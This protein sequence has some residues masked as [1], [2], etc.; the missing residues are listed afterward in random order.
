M[1]L[2]A[3][4]AS[5]SVP[6]H[7]KGH[8]HRR[9]AAVSF[10]W[11]N[12]DLPDPADVITS[13]PSSAPAV[14][15]AHEVAV[16]ASK[17]V[18]MPSTSPTL[19]FASSAS[20][21]SIG[22]Q[23]TTLSRRASLPD[24]A[25]EE[26]ITATASPV[27][28]QRTRRVAFSDDVQEIPSGEEGDTWMKSED[29][30]WPV[31]GTSSG[32]DDE[33]C[34]TID[35]SAA[36]PLVGHG[37]TSTTSSAG[38]LMSKVSAA[39]LEPSPAL[40]PSAIVKP[41]PG[42]PVLNKHR[43]KRSSF[44]QTTKNVLSRR[45]S[46]K[47]P[48]S[49]IPPT[50]MPSVM[51]LPPPRS[52]M[53]DLDM[54]L[55]PDSP[56]LRHKKSGSFNNLPPSPVKLKPRSAHRRAGSAPAD[57]LFSFSP[58]PASPDTRKRKMS[59]IVESPLSVQAFSMT[60]SPEPLSSQQAFH[61]SLSNSVLE[62]MTALEPA[63]PRTADSTGSSA[64]GSCAASSAGTLADS[65]MPGHLDAVDLQFYDH[66]NQPVPGGPGG[67]LRDATYDASPA[68]AALRA[69]ESEE[70]F[71]SLVST[72]GSSTKGDHSQLGS[73]ATGLK[74]AKRGW[75]GVLHRLLR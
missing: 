42:S 63:T 53:I 6:A 28:R 5:L 47:R 43:R 18:A 19:T 16:V 12:M 60:T 29:Y 74:S 9:S 41:V 39:A 51:P 13:H 35:L 71:R 23:D 22:D 7:K 26:T 40:E 44:L 25:E 11:R 36:G 24:V 21:S 61:L 70:G 50:I 72:A 48:I 10:D 62:E 68:L 1:S 69:L 75:K 49:P 54:A 2:H 57:I 32:S 3:K 15:P 4:S 37:T 52:S 65:C 17:I 34:A 64:M 38:S 55:A 66:D 46:K 31:G 14:V 59:A 33:E 8:R 73:S 45:P 30:S 27:L 20:E 58:R 56:R 67:M